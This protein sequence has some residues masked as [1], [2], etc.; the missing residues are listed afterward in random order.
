MKYKQLKMSEEVKSGDIWVTSI[1]D[2]YEIILKNGTIA[3]YEDES[4]KIRFQRGRVDF[5]KGEAIVLK[6]YE[7]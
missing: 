7:G 5:P 6:K 2:G 4:R 3:I 1:I